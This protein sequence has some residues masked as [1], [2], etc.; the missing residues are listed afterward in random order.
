MKTLLVDPSINLFFIAIVLHQA[1]KL[2]NHLIIPESLFA[3]DSIDTDNGQF[4]RVIRHVTQIDHPQLAVPE[5]YPLAVEVQIVSG[6]AF[7]CFPIT[8]VNRI[9][10][11]IG[12]KSVH[13][14]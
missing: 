14:L 11:H 6:L 2:L 8:V 10:L 3:Y 12:K 5:A 13:V 7:H 1:N 9:V 4:G